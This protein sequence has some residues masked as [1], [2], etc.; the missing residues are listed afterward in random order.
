[1]KYNKRTSYDIENNFLL[2]LLKDRGVLPV[3]PQE[4][5]KFTNPTIENEHNP[6]LLDHM[7]EGF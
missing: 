2:N 1:M 6:E 3:D 5:D 4:I 7:E